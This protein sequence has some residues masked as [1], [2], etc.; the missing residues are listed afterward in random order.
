MFLYGSK[1]NVSVLSSASNRCSDPFYLYNPR[2][3]YKSYR[4]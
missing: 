1:D 2:S 4:S 3:I